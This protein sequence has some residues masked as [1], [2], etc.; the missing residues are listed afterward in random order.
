[1][2]TFLSFLGAVAVFASTLIFGLTFGDVLVFDNIF[3]E[4]LYKVGTWVGAL[5]T[6]LLS[7][8]VLGVFL[9]AIRIS[10]AQ[11]HDTE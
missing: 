10:S 4:I 8:F 1:M 7:F 3:T 2:R 6:A 11:L 9:G 5:V